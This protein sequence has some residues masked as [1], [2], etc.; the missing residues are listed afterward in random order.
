M[1]EN[2][3][4]RELSMDELDKVVGGTDILVNGNLVSEAEAYNI[5]MALVDQFAYDV[6]AEMFCKMT[7]IS[8]NEISIVLSL[9][10]NGCFKNI[11]IF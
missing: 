3:N 11:R 7:K 4:K 8:T 9:F 1:S 6:A 10:Y 2:M 5:A